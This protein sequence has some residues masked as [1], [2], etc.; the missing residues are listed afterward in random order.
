MKGGYKISPVLL[1]A[2]FEMESCR[3]ERKRGNETGSRKRRIGG[4]SCGHHPTGHVGRQLDL[5]EG[6]AKT[7]ACELAFAHLESE[8]VLFDNIVRAT[9][10]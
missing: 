6:L 7:Q 1:E 10:A 5:E 3:C 4:Q 9:K 8:V 2:V